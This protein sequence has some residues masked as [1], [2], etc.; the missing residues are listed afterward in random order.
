MIK[1]QWNEA[2][3]KDDEEKKK[4]KEELEEA[5]ATINTLRSSLNEVNLLNA[6]LLYTNKIFKK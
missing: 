3:A 2:K 1:K 4:M 6:K 5:N